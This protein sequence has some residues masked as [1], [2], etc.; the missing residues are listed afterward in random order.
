MKRFDQLGLRSALHK[1]AVPGLSSLL[2][3]DQGLVPIGKYPEVG[4]VLQLEQSQ[5]AE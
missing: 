4:D 2:E 5:P 1:Q 3:P